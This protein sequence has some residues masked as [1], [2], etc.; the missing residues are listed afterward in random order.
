MEFDFFFQAEDGIRDVAVT[1]VQTCALPI[2]DF[3]DVGDAIVSD[4][5]EQVAAV[6]APNDTARHWSIKSG[7]QDPRRTFVYSRYNGQLVD[8]V[9]GVL[10]FVALQVRDPPSIGT[11]RGPSAVAARIGR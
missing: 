9:C 1:G 6:G 10:R 8:A 5:E 2:C 3:G 4:D 7:R 11:P